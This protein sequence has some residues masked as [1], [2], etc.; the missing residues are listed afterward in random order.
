[1]MKLKHLFVKRRVLVLTLALVAL[2]A[3]SGCGLFNSNNP[4]GKP[5]PTLPFPTNVVVTQGAEQP[6]SAPQG[7][8]AVS[9]GGDVFNDSNGN[10]AKDDGEPIIAGVTV[11]LA[12][13]DC[14]GTVQAQTT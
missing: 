11:L 2:I 9:I 6:T 4:N 3:L 8:N 13:G 12:S 14:P 5:T 10:G 7:G 1:M